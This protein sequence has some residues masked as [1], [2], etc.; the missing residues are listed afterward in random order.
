MVTPKYQLGDKVWRARTTTIEKHKTCPDCLGSK[1]VTVVLADYQCFSIPCETC[2]H[3]GLW[4]GPLGYVK[5]DEHVDYV[6][7][8]E[9]QG[10]EITEKGV[11][12]KTT[13]AYRVEED[14]LYPSKDQAEA[15]AK[16]LAEE[17][18]KR[19]ESKV[20]R[21]EK[22]HKKWAWHVR[23]YRSQI[24]DA[25]KTIERATAKLNYAKT[26]TKEIE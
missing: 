7:E 20:Y 14:Q 26:K 25:Q 18:T 4:E 22:D 9:I 8:M 2:D 11:E 1:C 10:I 19:E 16:T 13:K 21:K 15:V 12:Y 17:R 24:K 5:Y 3:R 6:E 23:Y